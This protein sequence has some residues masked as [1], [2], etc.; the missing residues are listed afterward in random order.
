MD[1]KWYMERQLNDLFRV[2]IGDLFFDI[3]FGKDKRAIKGD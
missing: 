1:F 2:S 3:D